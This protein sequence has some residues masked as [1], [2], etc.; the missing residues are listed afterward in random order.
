MPGATDVWLIIVF[1]QA[2]KMA[3]GNSYGLDPFPL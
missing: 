2:A 1:T 3:A